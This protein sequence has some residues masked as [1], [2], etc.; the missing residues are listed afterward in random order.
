MARQQ[1]DFIRLHM[2]FF[3]VVNLRLS[4]LDLE[5]PPPEFITFDDGSVREANAKDP[6]E[7]LF[8]RRNMSELTDEQIDACP[9]VVRGAEYF[10]VDSLAQELQGRASHE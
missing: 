2:H 10:Y 8:H 1:D 4:A 9:N 7:F 5:W 3:G 6:R